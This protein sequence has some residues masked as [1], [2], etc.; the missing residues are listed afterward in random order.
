M[1][2]MGSPADPPWAS[3]I[4]PYSAPG[5][6]QWVTRQPV[7]QGLFLGWNF[8]QCSSIAS[9]GFLCRAASA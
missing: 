8:F 3:E 7:V 5:R 4:L 2:V 9:A 6:R 1:L